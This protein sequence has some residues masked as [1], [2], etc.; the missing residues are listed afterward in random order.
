VTGKVQDVGF[1]HYVQKEA[2]A[3][4]IE[5]TVHNVDDGAVHILACGNSD[6]LDDLIDILY[7]G[8]RSSKVDNVLAEPLAQT[9]DFRG[10]FRVIGFIEQ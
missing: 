9:K 2:E 5:G 3:L 8:T 10:V 6:K 1:R 7:K 4:G